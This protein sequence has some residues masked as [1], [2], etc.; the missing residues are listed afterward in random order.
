MALVSF[1]DGS[2]ISPER[3]GGETESPRNI[4]TQKLIV[5][6]LTVAT[7]TVG[8]KPA[9]EKT[10]AEVN[11]QAAA[12]KVEMKSKDAAVAAKELTQAKKEYAY[13]QKAEFVAEKQTQLAEINRDL[14]LLAAKVEASSAAT[15]ADAQPK[16]QALREQGAKLNKQLEEAK[17]ATETTWDSVKS[18]SSKAY[19]DLKDGFQHARQ[20]VSDKIAP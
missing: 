17:A 3:V 4:M 9:A 2:R 12:E 19:D 13:A 10:P 14:D 5:T 16:L 1:K 6:F 11:V 7:F 15:K 18:A 8:C 20:W